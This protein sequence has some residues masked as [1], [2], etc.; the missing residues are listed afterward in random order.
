LT[1]LLQNLYIFTIIPERAPFLLRPLVRSIF[2]SVTAKL[3]LP[4]LEAAQK[5]IEE[6]LTKV[7]T[8]W[9]AGGEAP[10]SADFMMLFP[11]EAMQS[12]LPNIG[13]KTKA[14]VEM[15]HARPAY[16]RALEKGGKYDY[17]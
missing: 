16:Q 12:R 1:H 7:P 9:F 14:W 17:A 13:E 11:L 10:T 8:L 5:T 2:G 4:Q 15:A 6:H 3:I